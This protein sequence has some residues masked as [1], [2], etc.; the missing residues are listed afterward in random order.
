MRPSKWILLVFG[1]FALGAALVVGVVIAWQSGNRIAK[2]TPEALVA[3][4]RRWNEHGPASYNLDVSLSGSQNGSIHVEVRDGEVS[5]MSR[6]GIVPHQ[7]RTWEYWTVPGQFDTIEEESEMA[8]DPTGGFP[9]P[10]GA[11]V[12]Q[13]AEFDSTYGYPRR[14]HRSV[15]GTQLEIRWEVTSFRAVD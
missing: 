6:N 1:S 14:Y 4:Q 12:V 7:R 2:L 10:P 13:R 5:T 3:A 11:Q 9:A 15:L 8:K